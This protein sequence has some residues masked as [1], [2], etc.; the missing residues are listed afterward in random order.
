MGIQRALISVSDKSGVVEFAQ[1]LAA[2]GVEIISTG[3]TARA[4]EESGVTVQ[5]IQSVTGWPEMLGGRVKTLHPRVHGGILGRRNL[6]SDTA[7]MTEHDIP[8]IDLV[9]VN[10]YPFEQTV[11][12]GTATLAE[13]VEKIDIGG[14]TMVRA[15]AKN[16]AFVTVVVDPSD[17]HRVATEVEG[18]GETTLE[19]RR[20]LATKAFALTARYDAAIT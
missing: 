2:C 10:L 4:L 1:R 7:Q 15:S 14:P 12:D 13:A 9:V 20:E 6:E 3:G 16:H 18:S 17:Y 5:D 11:A 19:L 8:S